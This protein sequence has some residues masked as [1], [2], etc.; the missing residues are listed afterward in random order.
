M[1]NNLDFSKAS[2]L[3][4]GDIILDK[5]YIGEVN[6]I[7][8]EAP[9]PIVKINQVKETLGGAGNVAN[10]VANLKA[11]TY[12]IGAVGNDLEKNNIFS[13][14]KEKK[15]NHSLLKRNVPT[16]TKIRVLS[17]NQQIVRID[18]EDIKYLSNSEEH[19]LK[20]KILRII[21]RINCII[22][23]D[24]NK[25][26]I[27]ENLSKFL[28]EIAREK[29]IP[30]IVDPKGNNWYKYKKAT[31]ITPNIKELSQIVGNEIKNE[32]K[33]IEYYG[34]I[35]REKHEIE[36]LLVTRSEKG[37]TL[38]SKNE[39]FH[40]KSRAKEV[41]DVS[42]AGDTVVAV[43]SSAIS[44]GFDILDAVHIANVAAGIVVTKIGTAPINLKELELAI[45]NI[46]V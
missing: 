22:I 23:S 21:K 25:G 5:Y 20:S 26:L 15:I 24:Y 19:I 6:R 30:V 7:S 27:T 2:I 35:I 32:D 36:Y 3:V 44:S 11:K 43:L 40:I 1:L 38:I 37:M 17:R 39:I 12:L 45:T 18:F 16:T 10:N 31:I 42:G 4:V 33:E 13:L 28:I 46:E 29:D 9:V 41:Y 34:K 14:L 8:P